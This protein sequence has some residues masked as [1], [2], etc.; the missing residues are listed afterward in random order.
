MAVI[1]AVIFQKWLLIVSTRL[2]K[3]F[4]LLGKLAVVD[5]CDALVMVALL[6]GA[7]LNLKL[8][9][10]S[11]TCFQSGGNGNCARMIAVWLARLCIHDFYSWGCEA[12]ILAVAKDKQRRLVHWDCGPELHSDWL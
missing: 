2:V 6:N 10:C 4:L 9:P 8:W 11:K 12:G 7:F 3:R 5:P 1:G